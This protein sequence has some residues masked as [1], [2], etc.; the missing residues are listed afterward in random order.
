[1]LFRSVVPVARAIPSG[2]PELVRDQE[3]GLLV[4]EHPEAAAA[5]IG[6]LAR[7]PDLWRH[8]SR[9]ARS[10]VVATF[11]E[12]RCN[13]N[14]VA[15]LNQLQAKAKVVYPIRGFHGVRLSRVSPLLQGPH[16][17]PPFW[18]SQKLRQRIRTGMAIVKGGVKKRW[19][20]SA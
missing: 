13:D 12:D 6:T 1:M 15:L 5:A 18:R 16:H 8:C 20:P 7:D 14:W 4:T 2:I 19:K 11:N 9:Q 3:T 10:L 17:R